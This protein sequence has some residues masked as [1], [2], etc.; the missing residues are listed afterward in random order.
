MKFKDLEEGKK[1]IIASPYNHNYAVRDGLLYNITNDEF[2]SMCFCTAANTEFIE[3]VE[4][5]SFEEAVEHMKKG[6]NANYENY[7]ICTIIDDAIYHSVSGAPLFFKTE[8][9]EPKWILL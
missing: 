8:Y 6:K 4:Y 1:Y 5:V 3:V 9:L 2:S 7:L